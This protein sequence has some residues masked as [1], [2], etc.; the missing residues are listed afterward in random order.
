MNKL[1]DFITYSFLVAGIMVMTRP[2][3]KGP[4][5]VKSLTDGY[6]NI[7]KAATGGK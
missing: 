7:V 3:S 1:G 5:F 4:Q 2:G 6:A